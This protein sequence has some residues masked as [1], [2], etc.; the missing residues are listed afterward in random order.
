MKRITHGRVIARH[1]ANKQ[2]TITG[3]RAVALSRRITFSEFGKKLTIAAATLWLMMIAVSHAVAA[4]S[5]AA[6]IEQAIRNLL[7]DSRY[8]YIVA[9]TQSSNGAPEHYDSLRAEAVGES[10]PFGN[11]WVRVFFYSGGAIAHTA[12]L[13]AQVLWYQE[14]LVTTRSI[15]RGEAL[16]PELFTVMRREVTSIADPIVTG[17]DEIEGKEAARTIPQGKSLTFSMIKNEELI[18]RGDH[19]TIVY[20]NG[21]LQITASGEARQAG[22]RGE[23]IKI[24]N[25]STNKIITAEVLDEQSVKVVR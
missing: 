11:C 3:F 25:L 24:K 17:L 8:E 14:A 13:N 2:A 9:L 6:D 16:T 19:V 23:A 20:Q 1:S 4:P 15:T 7:T 21:N 10:Q 5:A 18:K 22:A 12:T